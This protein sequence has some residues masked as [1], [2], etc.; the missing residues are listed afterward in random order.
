MRAGGVLCGI[1]VKSGAAGL[2]KEDEV[3]G[4][5]V[6]G[7]V[8]PVNVDAVESPIFHE[9]DGGACESSPIVG[10]AGCRCEIC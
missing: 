10:R 4:L 7:G 6:V 9:G 8:F 1:G 3:T 2:K 5:G